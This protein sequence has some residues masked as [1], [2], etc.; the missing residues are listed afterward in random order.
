V[1]LGRPEI[2]ARLQ[3]YAQLRGEPGGNE[4][5]LLEAAL[6]L[7]ESFDIEIK[8]AEISPGTLGSFALM[9]QLVTQKLGGT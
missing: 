4:L 9:E 6:F 8:D 3:E 5:S 1:T 7:E 2:S